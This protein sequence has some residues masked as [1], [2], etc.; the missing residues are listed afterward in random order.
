MVS[1]S[2]EDIIRVLMTKPGEM[3]SEVYEPS[4]LSR[5]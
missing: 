5:L 2:L 1:S 4:S 3:R